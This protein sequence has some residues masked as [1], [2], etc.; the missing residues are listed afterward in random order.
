[1]ENTL[2]SKL[3]IPQ[4]QSVLIS[5]MTNSTD[6][7]VAEYV[8]RKSSNSKYSERAFAKAV[9]LSPGF[10]K[11]LFQGKKQ[12]SF[13]RANEVAHNLKWTESQKAKFL[14]SLQ[15]ESVKKAKTL[16]GKFLLSEIDF[17][18][19]SDWFHFA[20]I[21]LIKSQGSTA[22]LQ[23]ICQ[24]LAISKTEGAFALKHLTHLGMLEAVEKDHYRVPENYE[25]PS[26]TSQGIR[27][28]H[29]QMLQKAID[30]I[31]EQNTD[32]RDLRGLT[33]AFSPARLHE[34][35][36][37]IQNFVAQF[38]KKYGKGS[39]TSVYQLSTALF[40]LDKGES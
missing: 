17:F 33:L 32:R 30:A 18:E 40:R 27:K 3:L 16:K 34:A 1:M 28:Y 36:A 37:D 6:F 26:A 2:L 39:R 4:H 31:E 38:E 15:K 8:R 23:E 9:G 7:L 14:G 10:L 19:I 20:I 5:N 22:T 35:K 29:R 13:S 21:E 24:R 25:V 11:L 12:L